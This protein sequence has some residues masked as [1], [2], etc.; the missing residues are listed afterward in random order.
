MPKCPHH[1][2]KKL[3]D[4]SYK[5][6]GI[7][8]SYKSRFLLKT[9][10]FSSISLF[11][12]FCACSSALGRAEF[13]LRHLSSLCSPMFL[14]FPSNFLFIKK[15]LMFQ[16]AWHYLSC[17]WSSAFPPPWGLSPADPSP[18]TPLDVEMGGRTQQLSSSS[19]SP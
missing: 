6:Y 4:L 5:L 3:G 1:F 2:K 15:I 13:P 11:L 12:M 19:T 9:N 14:D 10:T 18:R 8:T 17:R 16:T 7:A